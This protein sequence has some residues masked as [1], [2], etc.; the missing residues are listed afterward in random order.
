[1]KT[2]KGKGGKHEESKQD[3]AVDETVFMTQYEE[4]HKN[5]HHGGGTRGNDSE[6]EEEDDGNPHG[7]R[8]GCQSQ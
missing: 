3:G 1:V 8:V 2:P 6:E 5:S 7:Q 4:H